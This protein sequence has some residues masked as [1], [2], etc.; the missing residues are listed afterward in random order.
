MLVPRPRSVAE[1]GWTA[2]MTVSPADIARDPRQYLSH[3]HDLMVRA[4]SLRL[5]ART[6]SF[7]AEL[8]WDDEVPL[9]PGDRHVVTITV[10]DDDA[11]EFLGAGQ[12]FTL[13]DGS[14]VGHGTISRQVFSEYG[15]C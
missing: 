10:L 11:P 12:R 13:W 2:A 3:T 15:P 9:N 5:P 6:R 1:T 7:P 14:E 8:C 4:S